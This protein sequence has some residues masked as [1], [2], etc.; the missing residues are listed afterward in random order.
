[1]DISSNTPPTSPQSTRLADYQPPAYLIDQAEL[2]FE[3]DPQQTRVSSILQVRRN[4]LVT[5]KHPLVLQ[6]QQLQLESVTLN[7]AEL[8]PSACS[9]DAESL[10]IAEVPAQ[11]E[12]RIVT[13]ISP[14]KNTALEGLYAS[15][16]L[17]C[18]QCE[19]QGFRRITY[20]LDRPD[21][22]AKYSTT[23]IAQKDQYPV[24]LSNGNPIAQGEYDDG[25]HWITWLDPFP[26]PSYLFAL[27]GGD[28]RVKEDQFTTQSG[29]LVHLRLFVEVEN[30]HKCDHALASLKLAMQW[31]EQVYGREYDLDIFMIVAVNDFNMGAM[32]NKGLNIFNAS[33]VL[34]SPDT[35]TDHDYYNI[36]SIIG[37]EYF[38]NWSGNRVTCR[39]WFQLSLK[40]GFTVFRDQQFSADLN[41]AA[42]KR[43]NDVNV[44]R[45]HQFAQDAG[46]MAHPVRPDTYIEISNFYTVTI[47]NKGAELIR[48]MYNIVGPERFRKGTD[49]YF[50]RHDGQAV[51]TDDFVAAI[52]QGA[53]V[54]LQQFKRWYTQAGTP[55]LHISEHYDAARKSYTLEVQQ[56]CPATPGQAHKEP[57]HIPLAIGLLDA[58]G[59]NVALRLAQENAASAEPTRILNI[60][61]KSE[62]FEFID[63]PT[64]PTISLLRGFSAPV[65]MHFP[66]ANETLAF[67]LAHDDD[68]FSRWEAGQQ[69][70]IN[71]MQGFLASGDPKSWKLPQLYTDSLSQVLRN[72]QLDQS[73]VA[74]ILTLPSEMYLAELNEPID[75]LS[76]HKVRTFMR[77]SIATALHDLFYAKY[78]KYHSQQPYAFNAQAMSER[79][80]KNLCLGY[81][82][83][84]DSKQSHALCVAQFEQANNMS[85]QLSALGYLADTQ[86]EE[87]HRALASFY[88]Q[89]K[90]DPQ[91]VDKWFSIQASSHLPDTLQ[92]VEK[93]LA[94]PAFT[95]KN[96]NKVRALVGRFCMG[97]PACF[98]ANDGAGYRFLADI[99]LELDPMNPQIAA[100][101]IAALSQWRR[102]QSPFREA[103]QAQL[104]RI[105]QGENLSKDSYEI[106]SKSLQQ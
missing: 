32:E 63:V 100:R 71:L 55:I 106:A 97:N 76:I 1:M 103:M 8:Q 53:E 3:L 101:L 24:L 22:L 49:L 36:Q 80:I 43:I 56:S 99:V 20:F 94:H 79:T 41:S 27:V 16:H 18:T 59:N 10:T 30:L 5:G 12:L 40:E 72:E 4:P 2:T 69:L 9:I 39:D 105:M 54:D 82:M 45:T 34:A 87:K 62:K 91:V 11:F 78:Q 52:E 29:R 104:S 92:Q 25:R 98:H 81:L 68:T 57:F 90:H 7:G 15:G 64:Q 66:R 61:H 102:Y 58:D 89:W 47:Y 85:D 6:G 48:M 44:L 38:H 65:K 26:K 51:T 74:Q 86:S 88:T 75:P 17:L 77:K 96:P 70:A 83:E 67:L 19:A 46:P 23:L 31:D 28:L 93:L 84:F 13:L 37:H 33:C 42:V 50:A 95:L 21:V 73:L 14:I 60:K 35:A